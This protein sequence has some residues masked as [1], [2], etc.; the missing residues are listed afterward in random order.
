M[1]PASPRKPDEE[2]AESAPL[3]DYGPYTDISDGTQLPTQ[4]TAGSSLLVR[5]LDSSFMK[6][7][8]SVVVVFFLVLLVMQYIQVQYTWLP[9]AIFGTLAFF[10][11]ERGIYLYAF[12]FLA[13]MKRVGD[14]LDLLIVMICFISEILAVTISVEVTLDDG[15]DRVIQVVGLYHILP[16]LMF[17]RIWRLYPFLR[18]CL[19]KPSQTP[20]LQPNLLAEDKKVGE[21]SSLE[22][23]KERSDELETV[24]DKLKEEHSSLLV[25]AKEDLL[26][27][28][29]SRRQ[30]IQE[31]EIQAEVR[32][33]N[34]KKQH[35]HEKII[36]NEK[37]RKL[38]FLLQQTSQVENSV[39][40]KR[41]QILENETLLQSL[42]N[43]PPLSNNNNNT[44]T[45]ATPTTPPQEE[46]LPSHQ[47]N[48]D[49]S[50]IY[51]E[52]QSLAS[53]ELST[54]LS[55]VDLNFPTPSQPQIEPEPESQTKPEPEP[56]PKLTSPSKSSSDD[57]LP[58]T[59][60]EEQAK[61]INEQKQSHDSSTGNGD[62]VDGVDGDTS[63]ASM[64]LDKSESSPRKERKTPSPPHRSESDLI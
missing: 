18:W 12:W 17:F 54:P 60:E 30:H 47:V 56:E 61:D 37:Q 4:N 39:A 26:Q 9:Y 13:F 59:Q 51:T 57:S 31:R 35:Q 64:E 38:D 55:T 27:S 63:V 42:K 53:A 62:S 45:T 46:D 10:L 41:Q 8:I 25:H 33:E 23:L 2:E 58:E 34:E 50:K 40:L 32:L 19:W 1:F 44:T 7:F 16:F 15:S 29:Q 3:T 28:Y 11:I 52:I 14:V 48:R 20:D 6:L 5:I 49:L 24:R 43:L 36:I 21:T 22:E